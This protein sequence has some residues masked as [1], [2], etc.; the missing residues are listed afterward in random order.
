MKDRIKRIIAI[1]LCIVL[2]FEAD[3]ITVC[4]DFFKHIGNHIITKADTRNDES[5]DMEEIESGYYDEMLSEGEMTIEGQEESSAVND[6]EITDNI[7]SE[8]VS[9]EEITSEEIPSEE[10]ATLEGNTEVTTEKTTLQG[11]IEITTEEKTSSANNVMDGTNIVYP[12]PQE[13][14]NNKNDINKIPSVFDINMGTVEVGTVNNITYLAPAQ[15]ETPRVCD[16]AEFEEGGYYRI[17]T[18]DDW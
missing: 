4:Y 5:T 14:L 17:Q 8:S 7:E 6:M 10:D 1:I 18:Y 12:K 9:E 16:V 3:R 15:V 13:V 11:N 2:I